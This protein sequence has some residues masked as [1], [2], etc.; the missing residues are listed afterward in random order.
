LLLLA[1]GLFGCRVGSDLMPLQVGR[2]WDYQ[3]HAPMAFASYVTTIKVD[4]DVS[5]ANG[6]GVELTSNLG[7]SRLAWQGDSLVAESLAGTQFMPPIPLL[8]R[9]EETHERAWKG[10]VVF[11]DRASPATATQSQKG[12]DDISFAGRKIRCIRSTVS[13]QTA[14]H[15]IELITWFSAGLGI[16][17][18]EQRTDDRLLIRLDLLDKPQA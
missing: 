13:V 3:V 17:R 11:V 4:R 16:V 18:Q 2:T 14:A 15:K 9:T 1:L 7:A 12:E 6:P 5:V 10:R 8:F